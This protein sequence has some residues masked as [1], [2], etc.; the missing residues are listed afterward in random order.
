MQTD[1]KTSTV[2]E[3]LCRRGKLLEVWI[4]SYAYYLHWCMTSYD[5]FLQLLFAFL[6]TK[7]PNDQMIQMTKSPI[8]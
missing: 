6:C 7:D 4:R 3:K 5:Y 8:R 1:W 2:S